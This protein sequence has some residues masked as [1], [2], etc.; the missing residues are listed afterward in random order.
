MAIGTL[1]WLGFTYICEIELRFVRFTCDAEQVGW[2]TPSSF[3][4]FLSLF[5]ATH[6]DVAADLRLTEVIKGSPVVLKLEAA[7]FSGATPDGSVGS[8][9]LRSRN[10]LMIKTTLG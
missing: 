3:D 8:Y 1:G 4:L 10:D 9:H 6:Q 7:K 2:L 5:V